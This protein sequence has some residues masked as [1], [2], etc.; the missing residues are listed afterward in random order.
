RS[1]QRHRR[2]ACVP[3][4]R[5]SNHQLVPTRW[6]PPLT[7]PMLNRELLRYRL[8]LTDREQLPR[9]LYP[10]QFVLT[11]ANEHQPRSGHEVADCARYEDL[12]RGG[13]GGDARR[14]VDRDP[15]QRRLVAL[16]LAGMHPRARLKSK[17]AC[18]ALDRAGALDGAAGSV[19][20]REQPIARRIDLDPRVDRELAA[21]VRVVTREEVTPSAVAHLG[22]ALGRAHEVDEQDGREEAIAGGRLHDV[23]DPFAERLDEVR[24]APTDEVA[25]ASELDEPRVGDAG[26]EI[27]RATRRL[28]RVTGLS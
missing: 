9:S 4:S 3:L 16:D 23:G 14:G 8:V 6:S 1:F 2:R 25:F 21:G 15:A 11:A 22:D 13:E 19:E 28:K 17:L 20:V 10:L 7:H 18:G 24:T 5:P 27:L 12:V 26:C